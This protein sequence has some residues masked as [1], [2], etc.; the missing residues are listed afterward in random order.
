MIICM[1]SLCA[2]NLW[3]PWERHESY[4]NFGLKKR[5]KVHYSIRS[6]GEVALSR[7]DDEDPALEA[8]LTFLVHDIASHPEHLVS[9]T[10]DLL[11]AVQKAANEAGNIDLNAPLCSDDE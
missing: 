1:A 4:R 2:T 8:F 9:L 11:A 10:G 7:A 6:N 5:D 3:V